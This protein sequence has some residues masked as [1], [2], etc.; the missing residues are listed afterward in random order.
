LKKKIRFK[1]SEKIENEEEISDRLSKEEKVFNKTLN[2]DNS[3]MNK[4]SIKSNIDLSKMKRTTTV[5]SIDLS[6]NSIENPGNSNSEKKE[7]LNFNS[8][9]SNI[10]TNT[11]I[12]F[13]NSTKFNS[14][15]NIESPTN[16]ISQNLGM[17]VTNNSN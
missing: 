16:T 15:A 17:D 6:A 14:L 9:G 2:N 4:E 10:L 11:K 8:N 3:N 1:I 5:F 13:L 12:N 7:Q